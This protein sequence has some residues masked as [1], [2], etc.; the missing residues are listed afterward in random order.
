MNKERILEIAD[1]IEAGHERMVFD[2]TEWGGE[3]PCG[4]AA[5][6]A[7]WTVARFG[8]NGRAMQIDHRRPLGGGRDVFDGAQ[9][10]FGLAYS[11]AQRLFA[12]NERRDG[13]DMWEVTAEHAVRTLRHLAET[14]NVDW[15]AT[16]VESA[17]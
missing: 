14:G 6:I 9:C 4:T 8:W 17:S 12:P 13:A 11:E 1:L 7:G 16:M 3:H 15:R 10:V 5:C 2:M